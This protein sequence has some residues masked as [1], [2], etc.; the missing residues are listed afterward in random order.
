MKK[1]RKILYWIVKH[2]KYWYQGRDNN[3]IS[4]IWTTDFKRAIRYK[5][6]EEAYK[7]WPT[8]EEIKPVYKREKL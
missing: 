1:N 8:E 7:E 5:T 2:R 6:K 3:G 4:V